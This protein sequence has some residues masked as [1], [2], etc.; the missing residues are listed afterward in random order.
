MIR[1]ED[2]VTPEIGKLLKSH[3]F[4]RTCGCMYATSVKHNGKEISFCEECELKDEG[5]GDEIEYVDY[6]NLI[7]LFNQNSENNEGTCSA[8]TYYEV[9][10]WIEKKF[11]VYI[12]FYPIF[13]VQED[14]CWTFDVFNLTKKKFRQMPD[15]DTNREKIMETAIQYVLETY[16][17]KQ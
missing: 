16:G 4:D 2:F 1:L 10:D 15:E 14:I 9:F 3:G 11:N 13:K 17:E 6:G 5:R 8:P 12:S 7:F